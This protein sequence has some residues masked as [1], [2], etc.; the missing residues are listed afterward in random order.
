MGGQTIRLSL[1]IPADALAQYYRG[2][3]RRIIAVADD[4]RR[5]QLPAASVRRF[6]TR[7]G[8]HG[9]FELRVDAAGKLLDIRRLPE[10]S[11]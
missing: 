6:V 1:A 2:H 8:I 9:R 11:R 10:T 5:V 7:E 4:G 3:A